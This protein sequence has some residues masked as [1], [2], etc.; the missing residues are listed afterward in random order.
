[1]ISQENNENDTTFTMLLVTLYFL[2]KT[3]I[4]AT[5]GIPKIIKQSRFIQCGAPNNYG[6]LYL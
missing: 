2:R 1:M 5:S 4:V 6:L 3:P